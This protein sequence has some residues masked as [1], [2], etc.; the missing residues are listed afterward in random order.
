M[1]MF[2]QR[3]TMGFD[4]SAIPCI[5][6]KFRWILSIPSICDDGV[7]ALLAI[8]AA[9]P[10]L[11]FKEAEIQ[12]LNEVIHAPMKAEWKT[13]G[14]TLVDTYRK[15]KHGDHPVFA[16]IR[17]IYDLNAGDKI[18]WYVPPTDCFTQHCFKERNGELSLYDGCGNVLEWWRFENLWPQEID[19]GDLEY[20]S[21]DVC[22]V[23]LT[24]RFD[25][26]YCAM[27]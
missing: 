17:R 24:L 25:R 26:A 13:L 11:S 20:A 9:R 7:E 1:D 3:K 16:W 8:K 2:G 15:D 22:T 6:R 21:S 5:K 14:V 12:H 23:Q 4:L 18:P 10:S 19:F 27:F